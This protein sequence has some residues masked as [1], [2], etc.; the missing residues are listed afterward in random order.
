M[1]QVLKYVIYFILGVTC[2]IDD[3]RTSLWARCRDNQGSGAEIQWGDT[4]SRA[5]PLTGSTSTNLYDNADSE[6]V[7]I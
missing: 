2:R 3:A 1:E 4:A 5:D 6:A 7:G